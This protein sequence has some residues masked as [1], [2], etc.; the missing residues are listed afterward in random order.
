MSLQG[1]CVDTF[2]TEESGLGNNSV[3]HSQALV[4]N[5]VVGYV[6]AEKTE[7]AALLPLKMEKE[8][9]SQHSSGSLLSYGCT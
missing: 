5:I 2:M 7:N 3:V 4:R 8:A 6:T 9:E 1:Y